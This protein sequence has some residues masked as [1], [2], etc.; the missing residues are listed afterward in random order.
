MNI[1]IVGKQNMLYWA[2][3]LF[4]ALEHTEHNSEL[5]LINNLPSYHESLRLASRVFARDKT[6]DVIAWSFSSKIK[7]F[8]PDL[9]I[10]VS[11]GFIPTYL[12]EIARQRSN[13]RLV[14]WIGDNIDGDSVT[15]LRLLDKIFVTDSG[16]IDVL[17]AKNIINVDYLPLAHNPGIFYPSEKRTRDG[18]VVFIGGYSVGRA[19]LF[20]QLSNNI[21]IIGKSWHK[22]KT[23]THEVIAKN[24]SISDVAQIYRS[25]SAVLNI[26]QEGNVI[27][28]LA[29]RVF[30][31]S[32]C[33]ALVI[34]DSVEDLSK[35]FL[36]GGE[37]LAYDTTE[38]L[39]E[40]IIKIK[41]NS[42]IYEKISISGCDKSIEEHKYLNRIESLI[43]KS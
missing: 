13:C 37:I 41:F 7:T 31:A 23:D 27:N 11:A 25:C 40:Y 35:C 3:N 42:K 19:K 9:I 15:K 36:I 30:E 29:M 16:F 12:F 22:Y 6:S 1:L 5:F 34:H 39:D 21:T 38:T 28:G 26:K 18:K 4:S 2:E 17:N 43:N 33:G 24:I 10:F 20:D 8:H 14:G 32:A